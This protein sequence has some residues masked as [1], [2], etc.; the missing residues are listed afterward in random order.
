M[1]RRP[2]SAALKSRDEIE[3]MRRAGAVVYRV[4]QRM[5][6]LATPGRTTAELNRVA[7]Q[8]IAEA[9]AE[10][11]FRGVKSRQAKFPF[12]AVLCTSVQ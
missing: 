8:M 2:R 4:L 7:E 9:G 6:E 11:L 12:P 10:P 1:K 5:G 3:K